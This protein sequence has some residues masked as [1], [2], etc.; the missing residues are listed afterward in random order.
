[1]TP[2]APLSA[3]A[4]AGLCPLHA[5]LT[6][7]VDDHEDRMREI[8]HYGPENIPKHEERLTGVEKSIDRLT[9]RIG[10]WAAAGMIA[11]GL[12]IQAFTRYV[13]GW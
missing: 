12:A 5:I 4:Q 3:N 11:G 1:M 8:E 13:L 7:Q 10:T 6:K 2:P 9:I